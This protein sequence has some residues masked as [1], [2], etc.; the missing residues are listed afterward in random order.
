MSMLCRFVAETGSSGAE[1][2]RSR[3]K[4]CCSLT[5]A[6]GFFRMC[7]GDCTGTG[8]GRTSE[9][10]TSFFGGV[11][12]S[13][14]SSQILSLRCMNIFFSPLRMRLLP[15]LVR[16]DALAMSSATASARP[17]YDLPDGV[18]FLPTAFGAT[19]GAVSRDMPMLEFVSTIPDTSAD[20]R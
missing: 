13:C 2:D 16:C 7:A 1:L 5:R 18:R 8:A 6:N 14:G 9:M 15:L 20:A 12:S 11:R 17:P 10:A 19:D 4:S 3:C